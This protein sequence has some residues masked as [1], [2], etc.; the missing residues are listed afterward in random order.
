MIFN[1]IALVILQ[2]KAVGGITPLLLHRSERRYPQSSIPQ[3][4]LLSVEQSQREILHCVQDDRNLWVTAILSPIIIY[5][6]YISIYLGWGERKVP[7]RIINTNI[8][9]IHS[10]HFLPSMSSRY[11]H[12]FPKKAHLRIE[13]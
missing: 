12:A 1:I 13:D 10:I 3:T 4:G 9:H 5:D 2:K 11:A 7:S 8:I 6:T